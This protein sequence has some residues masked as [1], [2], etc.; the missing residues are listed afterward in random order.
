MFI[1]HCQCNE[2]GKSIFSMA[3]KEKKNKEKIL[4]IK[5][6]SEQYSINKEKEK[7]LPELCFKQ[8]KVTRLLHYNCWL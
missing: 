1:P 4:F 5:L 8:N 2:P 7:H 6:R 3:R